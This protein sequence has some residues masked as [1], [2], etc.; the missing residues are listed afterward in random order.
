VEQ[1]GRD[2]RRLLERRRSSRSPLLV[3]TKESFGQFQNAVDAEVSLAVRLARQ[4]ASFRPDLVELRRELSL[5]FISL[6]DAGLVLGDDAVAPLG[7]A[8]GGV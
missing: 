1:L 7:V 3:F 5:S 8:V 4:R 2:P 6:P